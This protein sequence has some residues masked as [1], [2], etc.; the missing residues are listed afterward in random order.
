MERELDEIEE[1]KLQWTDML[2]K[3]YDRFLPWVTAARES[4]RPPAEQAEAVIE[5]LREVPFDAPRKIGKRSFDD[6]KFYNSVDEAFKKNGNISGKQFQALL[7]IAARYRSR[8]GGGKFDLL[9][10]QIKDSIENIAAEQERIA[11]A[12]ES[13]IESQKD[14]SAVFEAFKK[15]EFEAP[16]TRGKVV[17]DDRKFFESLRKQ[18]EAGR[19]LSEKQLASLR[20]LVQRYLPVLEDAEK[21]ASLLEISCEVK[22]P[23]SE[24]AAAPAPAAG[25]AAAMLE[26]LAKITAWDAPVKRGKFAFD[27]KKFYQSVAKQFEKGKALSEKQMTVLKRLDDKYKGKQS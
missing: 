17:F 21:I 22:E 24:A 15:V 13:A 4:G 12:R 7:A 10:Q 23:A 25:D 26:R 18:S 5:L 8:I 1:G 20:R 9:D 6:R 14:Y 11:D 27:E 16:V 3:F 2:H 19:P